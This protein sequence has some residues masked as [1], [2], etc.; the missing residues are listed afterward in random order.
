MKWAETLVKLARNAAR[1]VASDCRPLAR[2]VKELEGGCAWKVWLEDEPKTWERFCQQALNVP[3]PVL[4]KWIDGI[5]LL[6]SMCQ[7]KAMVESSAKT[8]GDSFGILP[9]KTVDKC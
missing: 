4:R 6:E 9:Q 2:F 3:E 8:T 5:E 7:D 1:Y